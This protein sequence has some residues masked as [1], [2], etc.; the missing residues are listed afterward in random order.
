MV[1][2]N[3]YQTKE[4]EGGIYS[5]IIEYTKQLRQKKSYIVRARA[6]GKNTHAQQEG[7]EDRGHG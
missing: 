7:N 6:G 2:D 5:T 3:G 1:R 4:D